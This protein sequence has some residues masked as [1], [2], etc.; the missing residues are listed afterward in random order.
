MEER[1]WKILGLQRVRF[2]FWIVLKQILLTNAE[3]ARRDLAVD[4]SC[5]ICGHDSEDT[6]HIIRDC[7]VA[8]EV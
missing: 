4:P 2:F 3:R 6:L 8:K 5:P 7:I 1:V